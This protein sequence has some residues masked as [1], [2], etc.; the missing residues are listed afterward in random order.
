MVSPRPSCISAPVSM[1][2]SPPSSR[3]ATSKETR[4][5]VEGRSKIIASVWPASGREARGTPLTRAFF[6]AAD[7]SR[8]RRRSAVVRS[9][10]PRKC[11]GAATGAL[12]GAFMRSVD[13]YH[14]ALLDRSAG[15]V[16][17]PHALGDFLLGDHERRQQP[18]D[19][20]SGRNDQDLLGHRR[21]GEIGRR[22]LELEA[23][24]Q[25]FPPHLLDDGG[26]AIIQF[27]EALAQ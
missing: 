7:M 10:R 12:T 24:H 4:V 3:M 1:I 9:S 20:V 18:H 26:P 11:R 5:R 16:K 27:G 25:A 17:T 8:M 19:I 14:E 22:N 13:G 15:G 21:L 23:D 6:I 2:V